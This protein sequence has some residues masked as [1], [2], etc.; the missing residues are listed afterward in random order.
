MANKEQL[1][2][3]KQGVKVWNN[4][5]KENPDLP[6]DLKFA[7]LKGLNLRGINLRMS[8]LSV[9]DL[10]NV[11]LAKSD[12]TNANLQ[13][14][15]LSDA[16]LQNA[17]L[18]KS[19][20]EKA[21]FKRAI[22][23]GAYISKSTF[24]EADF[25]E[26]DLSGSDLTGSDLS[27]TNLCQANFTNT[28]LQNTNF[29]AANLE[30]ANLQE[31]NLDNAIFTQATLTKAIFSDATMDKTI[32]IASDMSQALF[33][34]KVKHSGPSTISSD[35]IILSKGKIPD[36][37]LRGC[38]LS[39]W[40]IE[41]AK[42]ADPELSNEEI[43]KIQ[44]RM[45]DLRATQAI[46]ISPLFISYSHADSPFVNSLDNALTQKGVRF[47][48]DIHDAIAGRLEKQI[49]LAIRQNPIVVLVLSKNSLQ[50][51]WVEHEVRTARLLEKELGRDVLCPIALDD[52]WKSSSWP[53]RVMEQVME[54]NILDFSNWEDASMFK[55]K[56]VKLLN[57]LNLFYR[58]SKV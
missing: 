48:R 15:D 1:S 38:G 57:G 26:A 40:Q 19:S 8:N 37:F 35:T 23:R 30:Q 58:K 31:S 39:E 42:L 10:P 36:S 54:Y 56:F 22:L 52:H 50:S 3:L 29:T 34:D 25:T 32:F 2:I 18:G 20:F 43:V 5:R 55:R 6:I 45:F 9:A 14:V 51:D 21:T 27:R 33:L 53:S 28:N 4:W 46:Q 24:T 44:Y 16:N 13:D 12:L 41:T 47:W 11:N 49:D 7:K 17:S